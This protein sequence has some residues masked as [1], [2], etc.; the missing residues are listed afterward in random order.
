MTNN[1]S[2]CSHT[3]SAAVSEAP[4]QTSCN[5]ANPYDPSSAVEKKEEGQGGHKGRG[6]HPKDESSSPTETP[7]DL[8]MV[9]EHLQPIHKAS[10]YA[11]GAKNL[12]ALTQH[13]S[14]QIDAVAEDIEA[15]VEEMMG[16][17]AKKQKVSIEGGTILER[18]DIIEKSLSQLD[19]I[20][21]KLD[22]IAVT[23]RK[24]SWQRLRPTKSLDV[25]D[26]E[27]EVVSLSDAIESGGYTSGRVV[28]F[29]EDKG[30][31]FITSEGETCFFHRSSIMIHQRLPLGSPVIF[32]V[33]RDI[34]QGGEKLKATAVYSEPD[35]KVHRVKTQAA[36]A[37]EAAV[38]AA[39]AAQDRFE[40]AGIAMIREEVADL[41]PPPG[42]AAEQSRAEQTR[43]GCSS[44]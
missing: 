3:R 14:P 1:P 42:L 12:A 24:E 6:G 36:N 16:E 18:L 17:D 26:K 34:V 43:A 31:G 37:A 29:F 40:D 38:K 10:A 15:E 44:I 11:E 20:E 21:N 2:G 13:T 4:D 9:A 39:R 28:K 22:R 7:Y 5:A 33:I 32:Q 19:R 25:A 41:D 35:Y 30:Y 27:M 23:L 8:N